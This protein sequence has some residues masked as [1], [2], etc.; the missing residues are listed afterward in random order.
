MPCC[1]HMGK[2]SGRPL[3]ERRG[4]PEPLVYWYCERG[5]IYKLPAVGGGGLLKEFIPKQSRDRLTPWY[6][7]TGV[8]LDP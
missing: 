6:S 5:V 1:V 3:L 2:K 7:E 8:E 4:L